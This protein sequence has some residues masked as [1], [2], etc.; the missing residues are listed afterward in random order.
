MADGNLTVHLCAYVAERPPASLAGWCAQLFAESVANGGGAG[1]QVAAAAGRALASMAAKHAASVGG[2]PGVAEL[3]ALA[4]GHA[5]SVRSGMGQQCLVLVGHLQ[6]AAGLTAEAAQAWLAALTRAMQYEETLETKMAAL[7]SLRV[8]GASLLAHSRDARHAVVLLL[9]RGLQD[10]DD[11]VRVAVAATVAALFMPPPVPAGLD[12]LAAM[13]QCV[14]VLHPAS[15]SEVAA[16]L[17]VLLSLA[18]PQQGGDEPP[19][20]EPGSDEGDE[21]VFERE[22]CNMYCEPAQ[23][24]QLAVQAVMAMLTDGAEAPSLDARGSARPRTLA[25]ESAAE[26]VQTAVA[27]HHALASSLETEMARW[28]ACGEAAALANT[29]RTGTVAMLCS[30]LGLAACAFAVGALQPP[31]RDWSDQVLIKKS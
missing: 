15:D 17:R 27:A 8:G 25:P 18:T 23:L 14:Q 1:A 6:P 26:A 30:T 3:A 19:P 16:S 9:L 12:P 21:D 13:Q 24:C 5:G 11:D 28:A 4:L 2:L 29:A 22:D 10:E 7:D 20:G 31:A